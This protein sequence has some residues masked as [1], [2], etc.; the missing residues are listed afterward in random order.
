MLLEQVIFTLGLIIMISVLGLD[1]HAPSGSGLTV[2]ES[3]SSVTS[4][5][6]LNQNCIR[7]APFHI[8]AQPCPWTR[9]C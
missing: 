1:W 5:M 8:R 4:R 2:A 3:W 7:K 6:A 9:E